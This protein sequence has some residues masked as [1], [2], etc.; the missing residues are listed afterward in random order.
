MNLN[1]SPK[2]TRRYVL[3]GGTAC[4]SIGFVSPI[5]AQSGSIVTTAFGGVFEREFRKAAVEPFTK[6][7]GINVKIKLGGPGEW[8]TNALVNRRRPEIDLLFLPYPENI[9]VV[10]DELCELLTEAEIPNLKYLHPILRKQFRDYGAGMDYVSNAIAYRTDMIPNPPKSWK[11]LWDPSYKGKLVIPDIN[12]VGIWEMLV[13]SARLH[14]G[15]EGNMAPAFDGIKAL[16]ANVRKFYKSSVDLQQL[17]EAGEA[18]IAAVTPSNRGYDM[19]DSGKPIKF[20]IPTEGASVGLVTFHIAKNSPNADICKRF[21]NFALSKKPQE[22]FA[23]GMSA[24]PTTSHA[25]VN[26]RTKSRVPPIESMQFFDWFKLVPQ[27]SALAERW[28]REIAG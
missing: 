26:E 7:T 17:L 8:V 16:K 19:V 10:I 25:V 15:D 18:G 2:A 22:D 20:V 5:F 12:S 13:I 27:M 24:G 11:D 6:E 3:Q 28:N 14:G 4:L 9:R 23:N 21:I 1:S